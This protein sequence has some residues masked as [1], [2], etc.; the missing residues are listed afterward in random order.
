MFPSPTIAGRDD[1]CMGSFD[2]RL[3]IESCGSRAKQL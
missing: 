3:S 1:D 2:F